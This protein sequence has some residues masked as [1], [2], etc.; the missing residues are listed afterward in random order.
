MFINTLSLH[1]K[2]L[3]QRLSSWRQ[4]MQ[5]HVYEKEIHVPRPTVDCFRNYTNIP[6]NYYDGNLRMCVDYRQLNKR[7]IKDSYAL[8]R[9]EELLVTLAGPSV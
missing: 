1:E 4:K 6:N 9:I 8:P 2:P 7:T 5:P 3:L